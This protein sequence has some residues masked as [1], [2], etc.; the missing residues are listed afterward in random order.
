MIRVCK[1]LNLHN[2]REV[3]FYVWD[4]CA[5]KRVR[6]KGEYLGVL[7]NSRYRVIEYNDMEVYLE[8]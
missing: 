1:D 3:L 4:R 6:N 8:E 2:K 5:Y 7:M